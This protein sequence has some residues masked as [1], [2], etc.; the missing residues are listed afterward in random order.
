[1]ES[2]RR[3]ER[4]WPSKYSRPHVLPTVPCSVGVRVGERLLPYTVPVE[5]PDAAT[6][7]TRLLSGLQVGPQ[8]SKAI[9]QWKQMTT[10]GLA[11]PR[12]LAQHL[13]V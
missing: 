5:Y 7:R 10:S 8:E 9:V 12:H 1:M 6:G 4:P 13:L 11:S 2:P 3:Q